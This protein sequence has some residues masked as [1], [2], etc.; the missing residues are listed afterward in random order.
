MKRV[1]ITKGRAE[2]VFA[3]LTLLGLSFWFSLGF[4]FQHHNESYAWI[5]VLET[6]DLN[7]SFPD[8]VGPVVTPRP[9][10][11]ITAWA[12]FHLGSGSI[13]WVEAFNFFLALGSWYV[14]YACS[15]QARTF[16]IV[17]LLT[18]GV[19]FSGYIYLFHLHGVFYSP[20]LMFIAL[21]CSRSQHEASIKS[22]CLLFLGAVIASLFHP[23]ALV[24]LVIFLPFYAYEKKVSR[25]IYL[26]SIMLFLFAFLI[27]RVL[28]GGV[29]LALGPAQVE[30]LLASYRSVEVHDLVSLFAAALCLLTVFSIRGVGP[31]L[32]LLLPLMALLIICSSLANVPIVALWIVVCGVKLCWLRRWSLA[33][34]LGVAFTIPAVTATGSPTYTIFSLFVG[35][36]SLALDCTKVEEKLAHDIVRPLAVSLLVVVVGLS[37]LI[38]SGYRVPGLSSLAQPLLAEREKTWQMHKILQW[39][40]TASERKFPLLLHAEA[41]PPR[42]SGN[43]IERRSRPPTQQAYLDEYLSAHNSLVKPDALGMLKITFGEQELAAGSLVF[44]V[45]SNLAGSAQVYLVQPKTLDT[46]LFLR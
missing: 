44:S 42:L 32:R 25:P 18:T 37:G 12:L 40:E 2:V 11:I 19:M 38:R 6:M 1:R 20:L 31:Y 26:T 27:M 46:S 4:P 34:L 22:L 29:E 36:F 24:F 10:G 17:S 41:L 21:C 15:A 23:I 39:Y 9:L 45:P 3:M 33:A 14:L 30:G 35:S 43:A 13:L 8:A 5:G 28:A 7:S 16:S